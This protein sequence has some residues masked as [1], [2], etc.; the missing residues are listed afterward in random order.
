MTSDVSGIEKVGFGRVREFPRV[1]FSGTGM[2][3]ISRHE[4]FGNRV[5]RVFP[6]S[7][8]SGIGYQMLGNYSSLRIFIANIQ[9]FIFNLGPN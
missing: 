8:F 6:D 5:C 1:E 2:P 7:K 9:P 4:I 3:S